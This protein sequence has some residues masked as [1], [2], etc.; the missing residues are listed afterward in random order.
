MANL[1]FKQK[2]WENESRDSIW[3]DND[4]KL[5]KI[6]KESQGTE[7]EALKTLSRL[8]KNKSAL[9]QITVKFQKTKENNL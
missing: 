5:S 4:E 9:W 6:D 2:K 3:C 1:D 8:N 7:R